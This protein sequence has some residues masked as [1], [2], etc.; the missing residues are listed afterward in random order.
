MATGDDDGTVKLWKLDGDEKPTILNT[1]KLQDERF[2][3]Y[4]GDQAFSSDSKFLATSGPF[5]D[6]LIWNIHERKVAYR[7]KDHTASALCVA[8]SPDGK[9][10]ASGSQ[11][12]MVKLWD[13]ESRLLLGTREHGGPVTSVAFS[14][15]GKTLASGSEDNTIKLWDVVS[16]EL[17]AT[18]TGHSNTVSSVAFSPDSMMLASVS[19]DGMVKLW[20]LQTHETMA[21]LR[22][23]SSAIVDVAFSL[24]G[25]VLASSGL[26]GKLK[27]WD[28][29]AAM[30]QDSLEGQRVAFSTQD[31]GASPQETLMV[32]HSRGL[33]RIY[34]AA[35]VQRTI[36]E[37]AHPDGCVTRSP[38]GKCLAMGGRD[39]SVQVQ[40]IG[41]GETSVLPER[42]DG[43]V[44][45]VVY[46]PNG[47]TLASVGDDSLMLWDLVTPRRLARLEV[48][49]WA[50]PVFS[51]DSK[52]LATA[53]HDQ[54]TVYTL[55]LWDLTG[56]QLATFDQQDFPYFSLA[57]SADGK[58]LSCGRQS[59]HQDLERPISTTTAGAA[60]RSHRHRLL[61][62]VFA[63]QYQVRLVQ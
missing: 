49:R 19:R 30:R 5:G 35:N 39:G 36:Q 28:L 31:D 33:L 12:T 11:D 62:C 15:D 42:H 57:F 44:R 41:T 43:S 34:D 60:Q 63:R 10:L 3:C 26:D 40:C 55:T 17:N 51:P 48:D 14:S 7:L 54:P 37:F 59:R 8:F 16:L 32:W 25:K 13:I 20:S 23:H 9:L 1:G 6:V 53:C 18:L 38:D 58:M 2:W 4:F 21:T 29:P 50:V 46:A 47:K 45:H 24:D 22:G 61:A 52:S 27:L 56:K